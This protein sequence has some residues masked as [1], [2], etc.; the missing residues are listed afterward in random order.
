MAE[1]SLAKPFGP[2]LTWL[3]HHCN[4][5][6]AQRPHPVLRY[7]FTSRALPAPQVVHKDT[8]LPVT[9]SRANTLAHEISDHKGTPFKAGSRQAAETCLMSGATESLEAEC[10][11]PA[12][13]VSLCSSEG[14]MALYSASCGPC[15]SMRTHMYPQTC[16]A[17][18][19]K[20]CT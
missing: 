16:H 2:W 3:D 17:C 11:R 7:A 19:R 14:S 13:I 8:G 12:M 15:Q 6:S 9:A 1:T 18:K 5:Q 20:K 10:L 4:P